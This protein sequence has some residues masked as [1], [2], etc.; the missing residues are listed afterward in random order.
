MANQKQ[1]K[2]CGE[3]K[4]TTQFSKCSSRKDGL[5][6]KCKECNKKDNLIFRTQINPLHHYKWQSENKSKYNQ[7]CRD[8]KKADKLGTIY[9]IINPQGE[10][11]VGMTK[12]YFKVRMKEHRSHYN[13]FLKGKRNKLKGLH[14]SFDKY[15]IN[16][17]KWVKFVELDADREL[18]R[19]VEKT[20]IKE[21]KKQ[22][23]SLNIRN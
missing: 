18:L 21:F 11:Y 1:C 7:Y 2:Q 23:M 8:Y 5:Q 12:T 20:F 9:G 19:E 16:N 13:R 10:C 17:H 4:D 3:V 15:G 22:N 14:T 6:V